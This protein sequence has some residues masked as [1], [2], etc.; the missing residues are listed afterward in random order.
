[1][2]GKALGNVEAFGNAQQ[3]QT[4][5]TTTTNTAAAKGAAGGVWEEKTKRKRR[6]RAERHKVEVA[7][8]GKQ[9]ADLLV[10]VGWLVTLGEE[11]AESTN[12]G[13]LLLSGKGACRPPLWSTWHCMRNREPRKVPYE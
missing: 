6:E 13:T 2:T 4:R 8:S 10:A 12:R 3:T 9:E 7:G 1:M 5:D 11:G